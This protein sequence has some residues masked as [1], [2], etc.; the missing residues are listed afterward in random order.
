[1][2]ARIP[3]CGWCLF[4]ISE[5][6]CI[7]QATV[8]QCVRLTVRHPSLQ[9]PN[10]DI[11]YLHLMV[12]RMQPLDLRGA[13]GTKKTMKPVK[14]LRRLLNTK[15]TMKTNRSTSAY[16][17]IARIAAA[18]PVEGW[19]GQAGAERTRTY[20]LRPAKACRSLPGPAVAC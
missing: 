17:L 2:D 9:H 4:H 6:C 11:C 18:G 1:M 12:Y 13:M 5:P 19:E 14:H 10:R 15:K 16:A 7:L 8:H 3:K 20:R